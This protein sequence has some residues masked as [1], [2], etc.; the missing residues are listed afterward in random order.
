MAVDAAARHSVVERIR[1][2]MALAQSEA[3][4]AEIEH[5]LADGYAHALQLEAERMR[6]Q[7]RLG[8]IAAALAD[9]ASEENVLEIS[10]LAN[11]LSSADSDLNELRAML[12]TLRD[13][14]SELRA[15]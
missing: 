8:E 11:R 2:L 15:A 4:L 3:P 10:Q 12:G 13:R 1:S 14:A 5:T 7:K 9:D 6:I